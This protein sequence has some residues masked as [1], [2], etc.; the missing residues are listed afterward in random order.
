MKQQLSSIKTQTN[1]SI[2]F[3]E[4]DTRTY[5]RWGDNNLAPYALR[6]VVD[7]SPTLKAIIS[8]S[9]EFT[10]GNEISSDSNK[11]SVETIEAIIDDLWYYNGFSLLL[12]YNLLGELVNTEYVDYRTVRVDKDLDY[13]YILEIENG[14]VKNN[15]K[16]IKLWSGDQLD[17]RD[18]YVQLFYYKTNKFTN[19]YPT[20]TYASVI[21]YAATEAQ[22]GDF[23]YNTIKNNFMVNAIINFNNGIPEEDQ[24]IAIENRLNQKFT[25]SS[26]AAR[27]L[28]SFNDSKDQAVTVERLGDD[29]FDKKYTVLTRDIRRIIFVSMGAI[30]ALFGDIQSTGFNSVEFEESFKLINRTSIKPK[31][32]IIINQLKK[33]NINVTIKRFSLE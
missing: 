30:P 10:K 29:N 33:L 21:R 18:H 5:V 27:L 17:S 3:S 31:Q 22:I 20:P 6:D 23:H 15:T 13:A 2:D 19:I 24:Q 16:K 1:F 11:I 8:R 12:Y 26:N 25:G 32:D 9:Q 4:R 7:N 14:I 28:V